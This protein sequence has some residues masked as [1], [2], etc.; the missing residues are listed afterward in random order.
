[1]YQL[2]SEDG[3]AQAVID[4]LDGCQDPRFHHIISRAIHHLHAFVKEVEP[5]MEEWAQAI[6]WLTATGQMCDDK[7]QEW[8]LASD[9]LGVSM[10]V[11]T[12][13]NRSTKGQTE[14]TVLKARFMWRVRKFWK[15][16][17]ISQRKRWGVMLCRRPCQRYRW[18]SYCRGSFG[19]LANKCAWFLRCATT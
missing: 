6:E 10:L 17:P 9:V 2:F 19:Y 1:M 13:N 8:I 16:A 3:S 14:A 5:T 18:Q 11:E 15:M 12:I 7:R 4:R